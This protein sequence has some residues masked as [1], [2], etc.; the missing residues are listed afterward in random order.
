[1]SCIDQSFGLS[2][3]DNQLSN[4][5]IKDSIASNKISAC[6]LRVTNNFQFDGGLPGQVLVNTESGNAEW[7]D[8]TTRV[9]FNVLLKDQAGIPIAGPVT[10]FNQDELVLQGPPSLLLNVFRS[11]PTQATVSMNGGGSGGLPLHTMVT[12]INKTF[13]HQRQNDGIVCIRQ[14]QS[15]PNVPGAF[16]GGGIGNKVL[17]Q[18]S[19]FNGKSIQDLE[20]IRIRIRY[21]GDL[22]LPSNALYINIFVKCVTP[23][24]WVPGNTALT[25][26]IITANSVTVPAMATLTNVFSDITV[27]ATDP[28]WTIVGVPHYGLNSVGGPGLPL[29]NF[30]VP[31]GVPHITP[32]TC[33]NGT[34]TDNGMAFQSFAASIAVVNGDSVTLTPCITVINTVYIKFFGDSV[35]EYNF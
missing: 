8:L 35:K 4:L 29:S 12:H 17:L 9:F 19:E 2:P 7:E 26:A 16:N 31:I 27:L 15:A 23:S 1:M 24:T 22:P 11:G 5:N 32:Q 18:F 21:V 3:K 6:R 33:F 25:D 28:A 13:T 20:Y 10:I 30:T 14:G 34:L